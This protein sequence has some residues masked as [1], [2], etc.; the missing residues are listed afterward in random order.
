MQGQLGYELDL[1]KLSDDDFAE[2]KKQIA[3]YK[4]YGEVFHK[5]DLYRLYDPN[6]GVLASNE[7]V[8]EDGG[9]VIVTVMT[10]KASPNAPV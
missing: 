8:S 4:E 3:F 7:F 2:V 9:T 1:G 6:K 10:L 5:G